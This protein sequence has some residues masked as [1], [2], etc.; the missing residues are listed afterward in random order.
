MLEARLIEVAVNDQEELGFDWERL[1]STTL[2]FAEAGEPQNIGSGLMS[3][4]SLPGYSNEIVTDE[5]GNSLVYESVAGT[6]TGQ[7]PDQLGFTRQ[8]G[9]NSFGRQL[10]AFDVTLDPVA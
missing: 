10:T 8:D 9:I 7:I 2:I 5:N 6:Q 3:G 4:S 1:A